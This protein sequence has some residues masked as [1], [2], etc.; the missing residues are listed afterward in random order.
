M[1][2]SLGRRFRSLKI[3]FALRSYGVTGFQKHLRQLISRAEV[4]ERALL[5]A[6]KGVPGVVLFTPRR[7]S[8]VVFRVVSL[9]DK[10]DKLDAATRLEHENALNASVI[11]HANEDSSL[12]LTPTTVGGKNCVRIAIGSPNTEDRHVLDL[13]EKIR[14]LVDRAREEVGAEKQL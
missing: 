5:D 7:F 9:A 3:W 8:L 1:S 4:F 10:D 14:R 2:I 13:V 11:R 6:D 12:M